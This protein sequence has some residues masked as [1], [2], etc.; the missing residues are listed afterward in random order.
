M[1]AT[2][3]PFPG[4]T[5]DSSS[6]N[7]HPFLAELSAYAASAMR[8]IAQEMFEAA[9][10]ALYD[11]GERATSDAERRRYFEN[12]RT[13]RLQRGEIEEGFI[14]TLQAGFSANP[15]AAGQAAP[16]NNE[17]WLQ[18]TE[19]TETRVAI[20][21]LVARADRAH[22]ELIWE[23]ERRLA[24]AIR[25]FS[26]RISYR[27][28]LPQ[29]LGGTLGDMTIELPVE[30]DVK[31]ILLKLLE[32]RLIVELGNFYRGVL[33]IFQ[34]HGIGSAR[35]GSAKTSVTATATSAPAPPQSE[36]AATPS[37]VA[38]APPKP[39]A[40][41][42]AAPEEARAALANRWFDALTCA[43]LLAEPTRDGLEALRLPVIA[44]ALGDDSMLTDQQHPL[45]KKLAETVELAVAAHAGDHAAGARLQQRLAAWPRCSQTQAAALQSAL[46]A[47]ANFNHGALGPEWQSRLDQ[48]QAQAKESRA[49]V[50]RLIH[51][52]LDDELQMQ[53]LEPTLPSSVMPLLRSGLVLLLAVRLLRYGRSSAAFRD[54]QVLLDRV[55]NS[56]QRQRVPR[57]AEREALFASLGSALSDAGLNGA[58]TNELLQGLRD[59]FRSCAPAETIAAYSATSSLGDAVESPGAATP[60]AVEVSLE[61]QGHPAPT[62][63]AQG[64]IGLR[65]LLR[66]GA[67]YRVYDQQRRQTRW[68]KLESC[69]A[70]RDSLR[71][72]SLHTD[73]ELWL[74][75]S[76]F[77][78][79]LGAGVSELV[80]P[81][82]TERETLLRLRQR[83]ATPR[84][85]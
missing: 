68:L 27:A 37:E 50:I 21:G 2:I 39:P 79:D 73:E 3:R 34:R 1:A 67:W 28:L 72:T 24:Q 48:V 61:P 42:P 23:T 41:R 16:E 55:I 58:R 78:E 10:D 69:D 54:A 13:L 40:S 12:L 22:R 33:Q 53:Q 63:D 45:R 56:L 47:G 85:F 8:N 59:A 30:F 29:H 76:R 65:G 19:Q 14:A 31:L 62:D 35:G 44:A 36:T 84:P 6:K 81:N 46:T 75:M 5:G 7:G 11:I 70:T 71:F 26:L 9:D 83:Q 57:D 38:A 25:K 4:A 60:Q 32:R 82:D 52:R 20:A 51:R 18:S 43:G 80:N 17:L 64:E 77:L 15:P 49:Q 74:E 66:I